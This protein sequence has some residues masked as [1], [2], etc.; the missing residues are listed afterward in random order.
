MKASL[1][2]NDTNLSGRPYYN[3]RIDIDTETGVGQSSV[4]FQGQ[5]FKRSFS[6]ADS[7]LWEDVLE[8]FLH[9]KDN[10]LEKLITWDNGDTAV[11]PIG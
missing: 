3:N 5:T 9:K 6:L 11:G 2:L 7:S 1:I 10:I 8:A 4:K